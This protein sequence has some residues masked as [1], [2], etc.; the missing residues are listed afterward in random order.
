VGTTAHGVPGRLC[1]F[2]TAVGKWRDR[3]SGKDRRA[4]GGSGLAPL[5]PASTPP[6]KIWGGQG[7]LSGSPR[8]R[9]THAALLAATKGGA[10]AGSVWQPGPFP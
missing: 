7:W 9:F 4:G 3:A 2:F 10:G 1:R 5:W 6:L 8:R